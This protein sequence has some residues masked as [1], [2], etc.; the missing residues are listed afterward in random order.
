VNGTDFKVLHEFEN[1]DETDVVDDRRSAD[2][3]R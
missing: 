1:D 3:R 2:S